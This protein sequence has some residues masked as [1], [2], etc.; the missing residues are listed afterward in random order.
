MTGRTEN[1][2]K[3]TC[4]SYTLAGALPNRHNNPVK[5]LYEIETICADY[6]GTTPSHLIRGCEPIPTKTQQREIFIYY[7][8]H[9]AT[10]TKCKG[11]NPI[12]MNLGRFQSSSY[13]GPGKA[14]RPE[15]NPNSTHPPTTTGPSRQALNTR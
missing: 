2:L 8:R 1:F 5:C 3:T 6:Y 12:K 14:P 4:V 10:K 9:N 7:Y 11:K 13:S 15:H